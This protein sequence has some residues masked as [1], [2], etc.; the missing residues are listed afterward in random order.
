MLK[1]KHVFSLEQLATGWVTRKMAS[2]QRQQMASVSAVEEWGGLV[3]GPDPNYKKNQTPKPEPDTGYKHTAAPS[4]AN[5]ALEKPLK[6]LKCLI[7]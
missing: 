1:T 5:T 2:P 6:T 4:E 7:H 3:C